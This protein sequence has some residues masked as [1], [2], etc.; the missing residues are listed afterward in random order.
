VTFGTEH[1]FSHRLAQK[2]LFAAQPSLLSTNIERTA[3]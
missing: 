2:I 3:F 1:R